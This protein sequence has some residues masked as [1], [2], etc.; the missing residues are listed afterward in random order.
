MGR[1]SNSEQRRQEIITATIRVMARC[2]FTGASTQAIAGEAGL[3]TGL[4]HHHFANKAAILDAVLATLGEQLLAREQKLNA[5]SRGPWGPLNAFI[6]AHLALGEGASPEAL[7]TWIWIGSEALKGG[8]LA[9]SY[10]S[11]NQGRHARLVKI[12][13][14]LARRGGRRH[15]LPSLATDILCLIE[16]H[17]QLAATTELI[18]PGSAAKRVRRSSRLLL[19][20]GV[21]P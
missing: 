3:S 6:D 12:L 9:R 11:F 17:Y 13:R 2:G 21:S 7:S 16:G 5:A 19:E 1:P 10:A 14:E 20:L 18:A 8:T 15:A 4:L